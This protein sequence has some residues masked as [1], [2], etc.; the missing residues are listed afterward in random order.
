MSRLVLAT[1][2]ADKVR[3]LAPS[4]AAAGWTLVPV[5]EV[6][7]LWSVEETGA[8]LAENALL[9]AHAGVKATGLPTIA[10]DTGLFVD[11]L[12]G[13]PGVYASRFAGEGAT[14]DDNVARLLDALSGVPVGARTARFRTV[15][16]YVEPAGGEHCFEGCLEGSIGI[17]PT[18]NHGFGYDPVFVV[19]GDGRTLAEF[20]LNEKNRISHRARAM[21][22]CIAY[23][24]ERRDHG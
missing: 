4:F 16:A 2:N 3:E 1:G 21:A 18:G 7:A 14:Y 13:A 8:T 22:A 15:C 20:E 19:A 6:V 17:A 11:A 23:L 5:T 9:K 12:D 24:V 10:D